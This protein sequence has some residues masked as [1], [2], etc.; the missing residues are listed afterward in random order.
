MPSLEGT[1]PPS[2]TR[3]SPVDNTCLVPPAPPCFCTLHACQGVGSLHL[4][5]ASA[6]SRNNRHP[7]GPALLLL[8]RPVPDQHSS[9]SGTDYWA[10]LMYRGTRRWASWTGFEL[11]TTQSL[12]PT[13]ERRKEGEKSAAKRAPVCC[14]SIYL[15]GTVASN[16]RSSRRA[17]GMS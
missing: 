1:T 8:G 12:C 2:L 17:E 13:V 11:N 9:S 3:P 4:G 15:E 16:L 10:I 14:R 7:R 5:T 6:A